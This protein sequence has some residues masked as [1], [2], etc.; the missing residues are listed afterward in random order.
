MK[1]PSIYEIYGLLPRT[2][3]RQCG[4][5]CMGFAAHL[6]S[7][8]IQ[9]ESCLPLAEEEYAGNLK[10][11]RDLL[12]PT[13]QKE[14]TGLVIDEEKCNGCGICVAVCE[15]NVAE[16][17]AVAYG[18]GP[19]PDDHVALQVRNGKITLVDPYKCSR[20]SSSGPSCR[21]C[22]DRCPYDAIELY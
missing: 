10:A 11:L 16:S 8:D 13:L 6:A 1:K 14:I 12:G 9:P 20:V 22:V 18:Q 2:N 21:A 7:L 5:T 4:M 15:V 3:C 19:L 17:Q